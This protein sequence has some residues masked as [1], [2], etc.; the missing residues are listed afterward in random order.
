MRA[1]HRKVHDEPSWTAW[2]IVWQ[3]TWIPA[4]ALMWNTID[5]VRRWASSSSTQGKTGWCCGNGFLEGLWCGTSQTWL[6]R[7]LRLHTELDR[8]LSEWPNS[9]GGNWWRIFRRR[10]SYIWCSSRL[11]PWTNSVSV[12]HQWYAGKCQFSMSP[13]CRWQYHL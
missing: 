6:L 8:C 4:Y 10:P 12:L 2:F 5:P 11:S 3:S 7:Y 13:I 1:Y 9:T